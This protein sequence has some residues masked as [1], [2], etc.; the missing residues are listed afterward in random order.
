MLSPIEAPSAE[1][2]VNQLD[3]VHEKNVNR[4]NSFSDISDPFKPAIAIPSQISTAS[5]SVA[6]G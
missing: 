4:G 6:N 2:Y 3:R 1:S 5:N